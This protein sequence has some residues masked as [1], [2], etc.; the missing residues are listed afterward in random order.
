M[1][2]GDSGRFTKEAAQSTKCRDADIFFKLRFK[3]KR[4][5]ISKIIERKQIFFIKGNVLVN[6]LNK[7]TRE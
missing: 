4:F 5:M 6:V 2:K 7:R 3:N 1:H